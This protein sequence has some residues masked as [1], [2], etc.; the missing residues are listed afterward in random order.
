MTK[1]WFVIFLGMLCIAFQQICLADTCTQISEKLAGEWQFN[2][3]TLKFEGGKDSV[4][5]DGKQAIMST[6]MDISG[7][8]VSFFINGVYVIIY[9][10]KR[11]ETSA[12]MVMGLN[13]YELTPMT[14]SVPVPDLMEKLDGRQSFVAKYSQG[15]TQEFNHFSNSLKQAKFLEGI[16]TPLSSLISL[17]NQVSLT[18][19]ECGQENAFYSPQRQTII[20]CYEMFGKMIEGIQNEYANRVPQQA[21]EAAISGGLSFILMHELGHALIHILDLPVLGREED[22]AD[23]IGTYFLLQASGNRAANSLSGALWFFRENTLFYTQQHFSDEHSLGPQRQ[24]NLAC[25]AFGKNPRQ[26]AYLLGQGFL[27]QQRAERCSHEYQQL[28]S[29]MHKLL[30]ENLSL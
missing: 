28:E 19:E 30:G 25:W 7:I 8:N 9:P 27:T 22:A 6:C 5:L 24:A 23:Q 17:P 4:A 10:P 1:N 14:S 21:I 13:T 15:K 20:I 29:T 16:T 2:K 11:H 18:I 26:Y 3:H 12:K